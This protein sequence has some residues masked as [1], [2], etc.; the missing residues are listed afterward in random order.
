[1]VEEIKNKEQ[2]EQIKEN[3]LKQVFDY[4]IKYQNVVLWLCLR[5]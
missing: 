1:M 2:K 5:R 4:I 3:P